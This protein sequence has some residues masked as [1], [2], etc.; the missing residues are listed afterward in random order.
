[1]KH[2]AILYYDETKEF[3]THVIQV[4][5]VDRVQIW[6]NEDGKHTLELTAPT[7]QTLYVNGKDTHVTLKYGNTKC[8]IDVTNAASIDIY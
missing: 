6:L 1:M 8:Y 3:K 4:L 7:D 5:N 2:I